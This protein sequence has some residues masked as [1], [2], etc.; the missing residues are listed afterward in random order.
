MPAPRSH[1][2]SR[3]FARVSICATPILARAGKSGSCSSMRPERRRDR[4]ASA[5]ATKNVACGLPMLVQTASP[6]GPS[7]AAHAACR[8]SRASGMSRQPSRAAPIS[9]VTPPSPRACGL[10]QARAGL[11]RDAFAPV[12]R[13]SS[14]RDAARGVAAGLDLAAVGVA[15]AHEGVGARVA[16]R[17]DHDELVAADAA[18]RSAMRA[19]RRLVERQRMRRA[20]RARRSRCR[21]RAS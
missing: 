13:I 11:D 14:A 6:S 20:H 19:R 10:E 7:A 4:T 5:S 15:D 16:R 12:S 3:S 17:L 2:R 21:A 9:T 18:C 1:T 8:I